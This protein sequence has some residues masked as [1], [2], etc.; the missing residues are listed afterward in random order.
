M[1]KIYFFLLLCL[2]IQVFGQDV[3][4][5]SKPNPARLVNDYMQ[6][7][8]PAEV[9]A[10]ET[11]LRAFNDSTSTQVAVVIVPSLGNFDRNYFATEL[12]RSWGIGQKGK[13]NGVLLL[14]YYDHKEKRLR[15]YISTG[16]GTEG[17]L[18]DITCSR[19]CRDIITPTLKTGN[20]YSAL[21]KGT[22]E[23]IVNVVNE[24]SKSG[25]STQ[26]PISNA[27]IF[28]IVILIIVFVVIVVLVVRSSSGSSYGGGSYDSSSSWF[29]SSGSSDS[30]G[31]SFDF[32]GGD[33]GG[34]GG[35][36]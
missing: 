28:W 31:S 34:G 13:N 14:I 32:G 12:F 2:S 19:I 18:P 4:I 36:D 24:F 1:K 30:G 27:V 29:S 7:L 22:S 23:I 5:P 15:S 8:S 33:C 6:L 20:Y 10:L 3:T 16:Y 26:E 35:G 11:K 21:D 25:D 17:A 9:S